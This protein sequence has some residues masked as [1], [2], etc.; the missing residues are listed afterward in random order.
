LKKIILALALLLARPVFAAGYDMTIAHGDPA[1][2]LINGPRVVGATRGKPFLFLIPATGDKPLTFSAKNLPDGL[3]LD[4]KTGII[5]GSIAK[6]GSYQVELVAS[7][8]LGEAR[9]NLKI[10]AGQGKLALTPP[11][12]WNSW[13]VWGLQ[14]N[15]DRVKAAADAMVSSGLAAHGF[16]YV[17]ID[18]GWEK[19][20]AVADF[21]GSNLPLLHNFVPDR[22]AGRK[23]DG[24]IIP[25][26]R[27]KDMKALGDYIH[28]RGLK[29]GIYSSPGPW[30]CGGYEASY[31]HELQDAQTWASWGVDYLKYDYCSYGNLLPGATFKFRLE[32]NLGK[33]DWLDPIPGSTLD[34]YQRPYR[35]MGKHLATVNRDIVFSICNGGMGKVWEWGKEMGGNLWRTT[36]D[37]QDNWG[38][39]SRIGFKQPEIAQFGGPGH[40][41]DPDMLVVGVVGW[42]PFHHSTRL[43]Q[44]EQ[45]THITV[46]AMEAAP[47]LIGC[48]MTKLDRFTLDLLTN[49]DVLD[50]DQDPLGKEATVR[51]RTDD[52]E[53]W[54]RP[55]FDGTMAVA[56]FNK[57]TDPQEISAQW[58]E[59]GIKGSQHVRDLWLRK[60]L[61]DF[62]GVFKA[63]VPPH[64]AVMLKI[65]RPSE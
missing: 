54:S 18:D 40:W 64:G 51:T 53:I 57:T 24:T 13:N 33:H 35:E 41:N 32:R 49:D 34:D 39:I 25:N 55:L 62:S 27:F 45:V 31:G 29:F 11:L 8:K 17:N 2:P 28:S 26:R 5:S 15:A 56:M 7:N 38:S 59:L 50:V 6:E 46:W 14:V 36:A 21:P 30:T 37:I 63:T 52:Y 12:G 47:L 22:D 42:G 60:D 1:T 10:I 48:D 4:A 61:G 65:G 19:G 16:Q 3:N 9:R 23:K 58:S 44:A 43:T 20:H